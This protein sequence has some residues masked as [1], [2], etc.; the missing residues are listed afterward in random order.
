MNQSRMLS[1][2]DIHKVASHPTME[3]AV[4][5][6]GFVYGHKTSPASLPFSLYDT[7]SGN[8]TEL[9]SLVEGKKEDVDLPQ[10]IENSNYIANILR[11]A[12]SGDLSD[13]SLTELERFLH[14]NDEQIWEN[15]W[16]RIP[17]D[18]LGKFSRH[19]LEMDLLADKTNPSQG[20]RTDIHKFFFHQ[21]NQE[22]LRIPV[23]YLLKLALAEA[24]DPDKSFS[25]R[26]FQV[27]MKLLDHFLSDNTS[28]ETFSFTVTS[29]AKGVKLGHSVAKETAKRFLLTQL[30]VMYANEEFHLLK[31]GQRVMVFFSPHPPCRLKK[32]NNCISDVFYRE[33]FMNPCL[34]GWAQGEKKHEYMHLC[35]QVLSR[36]RLNTISKLK[37][38]GIITRNLVILPNMSNISLANNGVHVSLGSRKL[39]ERIKERASTGYGPLQEKYAGDMVIKILEHFL[40]LFI[41]TYSAAPYRLDF[42]DFHPECVL[43][44]LPHELDYTHIRMIWRRWKKKAKLGF[45]GHSLTPF[46]PSWIDRSISRLLSLKGDMIPDYRLIDYLAS[47]MSTEKSPAL[48]GMLSNQDRLKEDLHNLGIFDK[49]MSLYSF[50]KMR[51]FDVMGFSGFESRYHSLFP[52]FE[53]DMAYA[54]D[55]QNLLHT[56]AFKYLIEMKLD[57]GDIPDNPFIESERRQIIFGRAI[58]LPTFFIRHDTDNAFMKRILKNTN[59]I[60]KSKRYQGYLRV[61]H[62]EYCL[63]LVRMIRE[64][65]AELIE[66]M[67]M[68]GVLDDLTARIEDYFSYS[69]AGHLTKKVLKE[70]HVRSPLDL[71]GEQFNQTLERYYRDDLRKK[72]IH[73][74][75]RFFEE[76]VWILER[77][78]FWE[79]F[80]LSKTLSQLSDYSDVHHFVEA[81][82][83][84]VITERI[85]AT[86]LKRLIYLLLLTIHM[87]MT[88]GGEAGEEN[89]PLNLSF[90]S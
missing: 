67:K 7:T 2:Y 80:S 33:L 30:L 74:G 53:Q 11:R 87:D 66:A 23:S 58:D 56:L 73:E 26:V 90:G 55:L 12:T 34:S 21:Q 70:R 84:N 81:S 77:K 18:A 62:K 31:S 69:A 3:E 89:E 17:V 5:R 59:G 27:G 54:V 13:K 42:M 28:P 41:G 24:V 46:G 43:G 79:T 8:E 51:E 25:P 49:K 38:A 71:S 9:Q 14:E 48:D 19:I 68:E 52:S 64:D 22:Y 78:M 86:D 47:L 85:S 72:H 29:A 35:H 15:S 65:G 4:E 37:D 63:A 61:H 32:L 6:M 50:I 88:E 20:R 44:F 60:R 75:W 39:T 82:C 1:V 10:F 76:D 40:P 16:V 83:H 36:S 45:S 57:H